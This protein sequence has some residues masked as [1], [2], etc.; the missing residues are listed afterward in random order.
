[1]KTKMT[2]FK[3]ALQFILI[4]IVLLLAACNMTN[5]KEKKS[6]DV[7]PAFAT[8]AE[9]QDIFDS[10]KLT[11]E[12][13]VQQCLD[14]IKA[15]DHKGPALNAMITINPKAL[16]VARALD[17]ERK[18]KGSRGPLHGIP[19]ILKDNY[20]T[21]DLPTTGGSAILKNSQPVDDAFVVKRLREA[22]VVILGKANLSEFA[23]SY[24]WLGYGSAVGQTRNPHNPLRDPSGSSSGSAVAVAAGYAALGTG[25]CTAGS[26]R[27][28][29]AVCGVVG[30]KPTMGLLSRDGIIPASL[31]FDVPGPITRTMT[32][33][34]I[35]LGIM[36]GIDP[37]DPATQVS[38]GHTFDF[39]EALNANALQGARLG[40]VRTFNGANPDVDSVFASSLK[41]LEKEGAELFEIELPAP[42]D[43]LW[44]VMGPVVDG[45]FG[46]QIKTYLADL[47]EGA[48][49]TVEDLISIAESEAIARSATPLNPG[50]IR[51]FRDADASGG[52]ESVERR[53]SLEELI[54]AVQKQLMSILDDQ[55]LDAIIFP[56]LPCPASPR[57][58]AEGNTYVCNI[59]DPYRTCYIASSTGFPEITVPAGYTA[60][61]MP[62]GLSFV[63]RPFSEESLI[64]FAFDFEQ[65]TLAYRIPAHT[66]KLSQDESK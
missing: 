7:D 59:D 22:G 49:R 48:P 10:G 14:R 57:H 41:S 40:V 24:G 56:T 52:Y 4:C 50:R 34:A 5:Q 46:P 2:S 3:K 11:S 31:T 17:M 61:I 28:P 23:L 55:Q 25:T 35:M 20:N 1:M 47:P 30:I 26:I 12:Q 8:I 66:P 54:P 16:E 19:I 63:G 36:A 51:G 60:D 21:G 64:G 9:I 27:G 18:E 15:Y 45:D 53:R 33:A 37:A 29:S 39:Q 13:L 44:P 65:A 38:E 6:S 43:N 42:L 32:D 62:V 58:D